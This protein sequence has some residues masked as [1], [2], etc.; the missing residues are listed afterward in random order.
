MARI[1]LPSKM[2]TEVVFRSFSFADSLGVGETLSTAVTTATVYSGVDASPSSI[3]SGSAV[4][5][6]TTVAQKFTGGALGT[7]YSVVCTI[8]TS[9]AQTI[10][11]EGYLAVVRDLS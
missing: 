5:S 4:I 1:E 11:S 8:T 10:T 7:I 2:L 3:I 9:S 6:G